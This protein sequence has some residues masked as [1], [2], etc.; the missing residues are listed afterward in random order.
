MMLKRRG[1]DMAGL[2]A[3]VEALEASLGVIMQLLEPK[4]PTLLEQ[5][6]ELARRAREH[7][8]REES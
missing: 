1:S 4:P 6:K 7:R 3:R 2:E 8:Q 5:S